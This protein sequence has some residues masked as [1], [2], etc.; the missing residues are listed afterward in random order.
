VADTGPLL[1]LLERLRAAGASVALDDAGSGYSG[2]QQL[3]LAELLGSYAG[4]LDAWLLV[5]G[6][7][8]R[9]ELEAFVRLGVPLAQGFLLA[10]PGPGWPTLRPGGADALPRC[11]WWRRWWRR[12]PPSPPA[13]RRRPGRRCWRPPVQCSPLTGAAT[14]SSPGTRAT[15]RSTSSGP[16]CGTAT[17]RASCG[18][19][20]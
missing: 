14:A 19:S 17:G 10:E 13:T 4:R 12:S 18:S 5:E 8:G 15:A 9:E 1:G 20:P 11:T 2:L 7:E 16:V 6:I 3:A